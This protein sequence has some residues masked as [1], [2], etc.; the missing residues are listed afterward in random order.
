MFDL[1]IIYILGIVFL[2]SL[3]LN[4]VLIQ[5][6]HILKLVDKPN[7][8]S[9]HRVEKS[10]AGGLAIFLA[11]SL[12]LLI[13]DISINIYVIFSFFVIFL[14]GLY[15]D[16][17]SSSSKIKIFWIIIA[18]IFL[19]LGDMYISD[20]GVFL[21]KEIGLPSW[22]AI[23]FTTF[24]LVGFVNAVNLIDGIDGLCAGVSIVILIAY[25][26]LGFKYDDQ[27]LFY[28]ASFLIISLLGFL[29]F[30]WNPSKIFMGDSG[31]LTL[32][33]VIAVLSIHSV[34][35]DYITP[36]TVLLLTAVPILD[37]LVVMLRRIRNGQ[38]PF[39]ADKTHIHHIILKQHYQNVSKTSKL[40]IL[41]QA[42]FT[43]IGLGFKVRDDLIILTIFIMLFVLFY[44]LLTPKK[45]KLKKC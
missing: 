26:Y 16:R 41:L 37:T 35:K 29:W 15:D 20:L 4:K 31:S 2:I 33:F 40:L 36:T 18:T 43:Y 14:L 7:N 17:F 28:I 30:N 12:G 10:R 3:M 22:L 24:A 32:G 25:S 13:S 45:N 11:F 5:Y 21:G 19:V 9:M 34:E 6:S 42:V 8:R 38:N 44:A 23:I 1:N 39:K 27:F